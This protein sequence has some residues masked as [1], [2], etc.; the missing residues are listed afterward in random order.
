M[1]KW[2]VRAVAVVVIA[3][4]WWGVGAVGAA[5]VDAATGPDVASWQHPNGAPIDWGQVR[6]AG[7]DFA[8]IKA[9]EGPRSPGGAYYTNPYFT[10]D[11][12]GA[13]GAGLYRGAYHYARPKLPLS[14]AIEDARHF[15]SV[16]GSM[17]GP[18]DLP[19]VLDFEETGGLPPAS[20]AQWA[21]TWLQEV[22]RLTGRASII[23]PGYYF[24]RD[25]VGGPT[26]FGRYPLWIA[27]WTSAAAPAPIP[28][29][30][31]TWTFWQWTATGSSPGIPWTVDLNRFCCPDANLGLL[32]GG[33]PAFANPFGSLDGGTRTPTAVSVHGWVIDPDTTGSIAVH[34]Y[35]DGAFAGSTLAGSPRG[36]VGAAFPGFGGAHGF[37]FNAPAGPGAHTVCAFGMNTGAG[38]ANSLLGCH[39]I[40]GDPSGNLDVVARNVGG[41]VHVAGWALDPDVTT[42]IDVGIWVNGIPWMV[43]RADDGRPD[44]AAL[45]VSTTNHGFSVDVPG[46]TTVANVCVVALNVG[47]GASRGIGCRTVDARPTPFGA[48]DLA[49]VGNNGI[50]VK[51][52]AIDPNTAAPIPVHVYVDGQPKLAVQAS[53]SRP[54]VGAAF[55][56]WGNAHGYEAFIADPWI[57]E[58]EICVYGINTGP[59]GENPLLGCKRVRPKGEPFGSSDVLSAAPGGVRVVGWAIDPDMVY[60]AEVAVYIDGVPTRITADR[61]RDDVGAAY[62]FFGW[63]HGYDRVVPAAKGRHQVCVWALNVAQGMSHRPLACRDVTV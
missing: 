50:R 29:G 52:W 6:A 11:W 3:S 37:N 51:G 15:I 33:N 20:V 30:W 34:V 14:T 54:D 38:N 21:R 36:D 19:P 25:S 22:E 44:L 45:G 35:V 5:S 56:G 10:Q 18:L 40:G 8:F 48:V 63:W 17:Q 4:L 59:G 23:Y 27:N 2:L 32:A 43:A 47:S 61:R 55:P 12:N 26:D 42:P 49:E 41:A 46:L 58:H 9:D 7:H 53:D 31:G 24:W 16:T 62:P 13:A 60:P 28:A 57:Y 39:T 1:P